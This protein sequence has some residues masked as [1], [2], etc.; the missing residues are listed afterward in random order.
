MRMVSARVS[1]PAMPGT[2]WPRSQASSGCVLRQL[3]GSV[4]S[5]FTIR[6]SAAMVVASRSSGLMPALPIWG[7]VKVMSCPA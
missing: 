5:C 7:K 2:P 6:P 3:L 4:T 1:T